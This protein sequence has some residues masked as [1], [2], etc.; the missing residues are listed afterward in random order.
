MSLRYICPVKKVAIFASGTGS[1][2][3]KI[4]NHFRHHKQVSISLI[5][6]NSPDAGVLKIAGRENIPSL[7]I[8]RDSFLKGGAYVDELKKHGIDFIVLAGFLWKIP[9]TLI[10][11]Y[12]GKIINIH[13]A[14]LPKFGGK[15]MYGRH[16]HDAVIASG[17]QQSGI[18]I[19]FV[20]EI[21]DHGKIIFQASCP[22]E[23][24]DTA[25]S[26]SARIL[27]LEHE[28]YPLIIEELLT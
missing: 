17:E 12:P 14:L 13:P 8:E 6:S 20:D 15:G 22:V 27:Q 21:Y 5:V 3:E 28:H 10:K 4:I 11:A 26:L 23:K 7:V 2:A 25:H 9:A 16:V 24:D 1:N 18:T 19:H